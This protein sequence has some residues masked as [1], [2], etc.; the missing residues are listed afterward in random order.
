MMFSLSINRSKH[1]W[2]YDF[3]LFQTTPRTQRAIDVFVKTIIGRIILSFT[4][5]IIIN[6]RN[7][8]DK[9]AREFRAHL[10]A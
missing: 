10:P 4:I 8:I 3:P 2:L 6:I 1:I 7:Y 5:K 9:I